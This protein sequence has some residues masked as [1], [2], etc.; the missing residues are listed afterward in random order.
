METT[1]KVD[2]LIRDN[3]RN[4]SELCTATWI[5]KS[6]VMAVIEN[7]A[8]EKFAQGRRRKRPSQN[9]NQP[10]KKSVKNSSAVRKREMLFCQE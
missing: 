4:T 6:A 7:M 5:G 1:G 3:H 10:K 9:T 8:T 2:A